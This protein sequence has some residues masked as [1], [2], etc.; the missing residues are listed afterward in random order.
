[1]SEICKKCQNGIIQHTSFITDDD[2]TVHV[3]GC[4]KCSNSS[5][6]SIM[7]N[8]CKESG[9]D[10][11]FYMNTKIRK[12]NTEEWMACLFGE[13]IQRGIDSD[14][15]IHCKDSPLGN[16]YAPTLEE[17][18]QAN[19]GL[20]ME[21]MYDILDNKKQCIIQDYERLDLKL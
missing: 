15:H 21:K 19:I 1:M 2:K 20:V 5:Q 7:P 13:L 4:N 14:E 9:C 12:L 18:K 3:Y 11:E 6:E 8:P 10:S 16:Y 17:F